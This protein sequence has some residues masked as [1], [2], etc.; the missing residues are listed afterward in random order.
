MQKFK[1][2]RPGGTLALPG[3]TPALTSALFLSALSFPVALEGHSLYL[4]PDDFCRGALCRSLPSTS[5][6]R[7]S[8][9]PSANCSS[10]FAWDSGHAWRL[11]ACWPANWVPSGVSTPSILHARLL[12]GD[13]AFR[14]LIPP[15]WAP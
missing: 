14:E 2:R 8:S 13:P 12:P 5:S 1:T 15:S 9:T 6:R 3:N 11:S 10:P 7:P 4:A